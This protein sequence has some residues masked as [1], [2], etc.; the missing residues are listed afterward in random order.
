MIRLQ[1]EYDAIDFFGGISKTGATVPATKDRVK[2]AVKGLKL[3]SSF[4]LS[5]V[6]NGKFDWFHYESFDDYMAGTVTHTHFDTDSITV[7][8]D[9]K[10]KIASVKKYIFNLLEEDKNTCA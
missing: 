1:I 2:K 6:G 4:S 7:K 3:N 9:T 8:T 10:T 5:V